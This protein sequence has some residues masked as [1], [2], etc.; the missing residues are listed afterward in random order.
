[1]KNLDN[2]TESRFTS[3]EKQVRLL[4]EYLTECATYRGWAKKHVGD[5]VPA[6]CSRAKKNIRWC[7]AAGW[8]YAHID[9][10]AVHGGSRSARLERINFCPFCGEKLISEK[11]ERARL[12]ELSSDEIED[13]EKTIWRNWENSVTGEVKS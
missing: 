3:L 7:S 1:M 4:R 12:M 6:C 2:D 9:G 13:V 10:F 8:W 5:I 11:E